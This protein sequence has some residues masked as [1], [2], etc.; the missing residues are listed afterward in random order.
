M[1][2]YNDKIHKMPIILFSFW[3]A[4]LLYTKKNHKYKKKTVE[5]TLIHIIE[6]K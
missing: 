2:H 1:I 4:N 6:F 3:F 5:N